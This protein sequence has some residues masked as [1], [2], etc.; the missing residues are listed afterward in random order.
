MRQFRADGVK[1]SQL[2][3]TDLE[4]KFIDIGYEL[5]R[6][7]SK[8][9]A[10]FVV[11]DMLD[12]EDQRL[13]SLRGKVTIIHAASFFHLFTWTQQLYVGKRL[14]SFLKEGTKNAVVFGKQIG[15]TNTAGQS[16]T[17]SV[18]YLHDQRSFQKLWD[19]VGKLTATK[20]S[21][22]MEPCGDVNSGAPG[23]DKSAI[24]VQFIVY[25]LM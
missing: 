2:I 24:P 15:T 23:V 17:A 1:G 21:V 9:Q 14:V 8:L 12:P 19:E 16:I 22:D 6:D 4:A 10:T 18:P 7:S 20:W 25:Q 13:S 3:G 11:G 5:F